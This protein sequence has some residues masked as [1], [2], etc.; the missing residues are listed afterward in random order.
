MTFDKSLIPVLQAIRD[1]SEGMIDRG[2][3]NIGYKITEE[4]AARL[5]EAM[6]DTLI[7]R[8]AYPEPKVWIEP[9]K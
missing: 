3:D 9:T 8:C 6:V 7:E 4:E 1:P 2:L 5:W